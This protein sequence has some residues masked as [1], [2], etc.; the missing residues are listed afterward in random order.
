MPLLYPPTQS[1]LLSLL[2]IINIHS[3]DKYKWYVHKC[4]HIAHPC[5]NSCVCAT[6]LSLILHTVG[7][8]V[9]AS[10]ALCSS[11]AGSVLV[12]LP[13]GLL[14]FLYVYWGP[15]VKRLQPVSWSSPASAGGWG[16]TAP[17]RRQ[18]PRLSCIHNVHWIPFLGCVVHNPNDDQKKDEWG[19][20]GSPV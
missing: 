5:S 9:K 6:C 3:Y 1:P 18:S 11:V 13:W 8:Y 17:G 7:R 2:W 10:T 12:Y 20:A 16:I 19:P 4:P 15:L 14:S